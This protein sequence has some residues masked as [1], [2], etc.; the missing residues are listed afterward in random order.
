[1][2]KTFLLLVSAVSLAVASA[3]SSWSVQLYQPTVV[4]GTT[5]KAG[6]VKIEVKDNKITFKQGKT[7]I[8]ADVK[9]ETA[10]DKFVYTTVG[11]KDSTTH[12]IRD[13]TLGGTTTRVVFSG[14]S[15]I[16]PAP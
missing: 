8:Q 13:I 12:E 16:T 1:M 9:V 14:N 7:T 4:N 2:L 15:Q 11:Y 10:K 5:L 6:D 3:A